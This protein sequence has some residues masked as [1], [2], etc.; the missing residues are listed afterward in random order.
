MTRKERHERSN[1]SR[2]RERERE[3]LYPSSQVRAQKGEIEEGSGITTWNAKQEDCC[4]LL[5]RL[6]NDARMPKTSSDEMM[7][8]FLS[9]FLSSSSPFSSDE[10]RRRSFVTQLMDSSSCVLS[11]SGS[12]FY[13]LHVLRLSLIFLRLLV[14][15]FRKTPRIS[16]TRHH[17]TRGREWGSRGM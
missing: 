2:E 10:E 7:I 6:T 12:L 1:R 8:F 17:H 14:S 11:L 5:Q 15:F 3:D 13:F 16:R 9:F 4:L